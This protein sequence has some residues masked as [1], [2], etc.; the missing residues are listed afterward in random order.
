[1]FALELAIIGLNKFLF[2]IIATLQVSLLLRSLRFVFISTVKLL[3]PSLN[4]ITYLSSV[5]M[6]ILKLRF[7]C[8]RISR[9]LL[10]GVLGTGVFPASLFISK[11]SNVDISVNLS[12]SVAIATCQMLSNCFWRIFVQKYFRLQFPA[13]NSLVKKRNVPGP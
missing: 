1:M 11:S 12:E 10:N 5:S 8:A 3:F 4:S 13:L 2:L 7:A 6:K 9:F